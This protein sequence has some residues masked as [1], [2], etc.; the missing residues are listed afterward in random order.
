MAI[1][2]CLNDGARARVDI[3]LLKD[4]QRRRSSIWDKWGIE[5][6]TRVVVELRKK[7]LSLMYISGEQPVYGPE[8]LSIRYANTANNEHRNVFIEDG[9]VMFVTWYYKGYAIRGDMKIIH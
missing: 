4:E 7:L 9:I 8:I 6:W 5:Q 1:G 2:S 3:R